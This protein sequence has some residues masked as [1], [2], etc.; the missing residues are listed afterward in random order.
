MRPNGGGEESSA[1]HTYSEKGFDSQSTEGLARAIESTRRR[2]T[3]VFMLSFDTKGS[4][5]KWLTREVEIRR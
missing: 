5:E 3:M 1:E 2:Q 4:K